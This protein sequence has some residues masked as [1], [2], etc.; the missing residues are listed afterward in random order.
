[1]ETC[2]Q[3]FKCKKTECV[4]HKADGLKCWEI[5]GSLCSAHND[6]LNILQTLFEDKKEYC[7]LCFYYKYR[8]DKDN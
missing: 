1:M 5:D 7:K 6:D 3:F 8:N 4:A 2:Y